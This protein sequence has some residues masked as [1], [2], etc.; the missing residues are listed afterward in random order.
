M[1]TL[2]LTDW[3]LGGAV[4]TVFVLTACGGGNAAP[5]ELQS[6]QGAATEAA[7]GGGREGD[8]A[9]GR[10]KFE[11][12]TLSNRADL[13]SDGNALVE[14][15]V[16]ASVPMSKVKVTLNGADIT[17]TLTANAA[18][19][20]LRGV[21]TGL[22]IGE[23]RLAA[24]PSRHEREHGH[25]RDGGQ[26]ASL[27]ITNHPRGGPVL[28][29][30]QTTP[31]ICATPLPV[32]ASGN[33]PASNASG[34]TTTAVDAQ[35]N[36]A[37]ETRLFYRTT[38]A[39]C[40]SALPDPSPPAAQP[41]NNCFK[42]YTP[43]TTPADLATTTTNHGVTVPYIV[44]VERGTMNR[45]IYDIVVLFDPTKPWTP[46]APQPQWNGK[47]LYSFGASTGQ[48]RLQFRTEQ[49]WADHAALS[50]G[51]MVV[52]NSL[53][54]SLYNS[55]RVLVA[56][57]VM[58]MKEH[59]VDTY[60]EILY[61]LGNGCS[62][63]SIQ[64][65]TVASIYP[66]LLDGIQPSCDYPDSIT[67]G[68]EVIDC[69]L[70]VNAY[71]DPLWTALMTG[72][73]QEQINAKKTAINGHLDHIG[74]QS[75][76]NA[77]GFNNKP[78]NYARTVVANQTTGAL[79]TLA[80]SRNN[81]L[82]P[83]ALVYDPVTNPTGTRCGDADLSTAVWGST[84]NAN[85]PGNLRARQTGDNVGIQYGL[86]A[87]LSGAI[88]AEEFVTLN[89]KIGGTDA[90]SNRIATRTTAD[91]PAL[92]IAYR[93]GIVASGKNLGKLPII[94]SRGYDEQGIHY[95]WRSFSERARID[96]A[97][98]G[99]H[100]NHVMWRYG[101]GLLPATAAQVNAVTVA[102]LV[103]MDTWLTT[104]LGTAPKAT[105]NSVRTQQQVIA[106]KPTTALDLCYLANDPN[107]ATPI[108]DMALCDAEPRLQKHASPRQVA[109]GSL[110][111]DILKCRLKPINTAEYLP[112]SFTAEQLNRLYA[113]FPDGV[114][115]WSKPGIGQQPARSPL[116]FAAGP[117][118][119]RLPPEPNSGT[120]RRDD[121]D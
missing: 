14:V 4:A 93:A 71:V 29:G 101:T 87:L 27:T 46:L 77:F 37:T 47:V 115:D 9:G 110:S 40:S 85:A 105:L 7:A 25:D 113:T 88:T 76:N 1:R 103:T 21:V 94:D 69:V 117:G 63:G 8:G 104:L 19:R 23:N 83:A 73:S 49:N 32:A 44:R 91:E 10:S 74:C 108:T 54:D 65:N 26:Q 61:T 59:I 39:G 75:W 118:G 56:E 17:G 16:P 38:T 50:R 20:T 84:D 35:C 66:G 24:S 95:I 92:R 114:C 119:H 109:G 121:D 6:G 57:T 45:G 102:S 43:G 12:R 80:E 98:N 67:T 97:N 89:E 62:G 36:I 107:F 99:N 3:R 51:F 58:L 13:V 11:L 48:S 120:S 116:T 96:A 28:L 55:N 53:T 60:G 106:A 30:S 90:D 2:H 81:C 68:M 18:A 72:L 41:S 31:W 64:Q 33:T 82:L 79:V 100:G 86:K 34:L 42:P 15:R 22:R 112:A 70:L 111:E 5:E 78:G 52:D